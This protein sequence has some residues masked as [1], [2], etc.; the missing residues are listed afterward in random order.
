MYTRLCER[1]LDASET[2]SDASKY[3]MGKYEF[4]LH[5]DFAGKD[6]FVRRFDF[7]LYLA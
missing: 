5:A 1:T 7:V 3:K 6:E 4:V 2:R